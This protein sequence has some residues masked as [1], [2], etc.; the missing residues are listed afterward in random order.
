MFDI[1][2][3]I[4]IEQ[5]TTLVPCYLEAR[6]DGR[7]GRVEFSSADLES[8][9]SSNFV[10]SASTVL[11]D[12]DVRA[13]LALPEVQEIIAGRAAKTTLKQA[14]LS[15]GVS[16]RVAAAVAASVA[17]ESEVAK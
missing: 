17:A 16:S 11:T 5:E 15:T 2:A 10:Q 3:K 13:I 9:D 7:G 8:P 12:E 1:L 4:Q 6:L 14:K